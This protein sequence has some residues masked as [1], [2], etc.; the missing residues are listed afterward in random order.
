MLVQFYCMTYL[1]A[2]LASMAGYFAVIAVFPKL[3][4]LDFPERYGL[5]RPRLPYPAGIVAVVVFLS[6]FAWHSEFRE[7][8]IGVMIAVGLL[9]IVS[10]IDDRTPLSPWVRLLVQILAAFTV[11]AAGSRIYTL[12]NPL[13]GILKLDTFIVNA[14]PLG[15]LP[16]LAGIFTVAW[17]LFTTNAMNW[18]DGVS[19]QVSIVS[20]IAFV[21]LGLLALLRNGEPRTA[22]IAFILAGIALA[23]CLFDFPPAKVLMGDTGSMFFGFML[24]LLGVYSGGKV[25]TVFLALGVPLLDALFVIIRRI[26]RGDSPLRGG[27]DHLHHLLLDRGYSER[28][29]IL[30]IASIGTAFGV[31]ALFMNTAEKGLAILALV[32]GVFLITSLARKTK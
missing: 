24:G 30:I 25:A 3:G 19:G 32:I 5:Q 12:T 16:V 20:F 1:V 26:S 8:Q 28:Q 17:L 29:V 21:M 18:L 9:G 7:Q 4:L 23:G 10:F 6:F 2:F 22:E 27:R 13:G 14:G 11:F 31:G 15:T